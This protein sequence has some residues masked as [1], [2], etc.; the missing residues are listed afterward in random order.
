MHDPSRPH[1]HRE[2]ADKRKKALT[3]AGVIVIL[4]IVVVLHL[5]GVVPH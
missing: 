5:T 3:V 1:G 2:R 4:A